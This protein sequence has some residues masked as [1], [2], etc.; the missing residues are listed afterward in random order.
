MS[1]DLG[2]DLVQGDRSGG[3]RTAGVD[4]EMH[5]IAVMEAVGGRG[6]GDRGVRR[7]RSRADHSGR[8]C[9]GHVDGDRDHRRD[10]GEEAR[11]STCPL[12]EED[13]EL[14]FTSSLSAVA[15]VLARRSIS[16]GTA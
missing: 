3:G 1:T 16:A 7:G 2:F 13:Q 4:V 12:P 15:G 11:V 8:G 14:P 10:R 9:P 5:R 6:K